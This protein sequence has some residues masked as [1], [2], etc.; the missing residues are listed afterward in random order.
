MRLS[1]NKK[2]DDLSSEI[3]RTLTRRCSIK[4]GSARKCYLAD[5]FYPSKDAVDRSNLLQQLFDMFFQFRRRDG[6]CKSTNYIS[7]AVYQEFR[8]VPLNFSCIY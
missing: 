8:K 7:A 3:S 5:P 6:W 2:G 4:K 1:Q